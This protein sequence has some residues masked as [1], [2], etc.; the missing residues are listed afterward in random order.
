[1][2]PKMPRIW[3]VTVVPSV[4]AVGGSRALRCST[5]LLTLVRD[6]LFPFGLAHGGSVAHHNEIGEHTDLG[7]GQSFGHNRVEPNKGT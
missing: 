1:M 7:A 3:Q 5:D 6:A 2:L 4:T